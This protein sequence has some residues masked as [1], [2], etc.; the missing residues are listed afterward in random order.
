MYDCRDADRDWVAG[1]D[2]LDGPASSEDEC[3]RE[4]RD[5][6]MSPSPPNE[7]RGRMEG[8]YDVLLD[9]LTV[10]DP[11]P[12]FPGRP[13]GR[14]MVPEPSSDDLEP[15]PDLDETRAFKAGRVGEVAR[16]VP[17]LDGDSR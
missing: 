5:M 17:A 10:P 12:V 3:G 8:R 6:G 14:R 15:D 7:A 11:A 13:E 1:E 2:E 16:D 9:V 4:G